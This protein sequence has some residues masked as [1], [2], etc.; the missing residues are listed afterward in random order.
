MSEVGSRT[1]AQYLK[2]DG[3]LPCLGPRVNLYILCKLAFLKHTFIRVFI[4]NSSILAL[5]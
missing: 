3:I 1:F 4:E 5:I 2:A